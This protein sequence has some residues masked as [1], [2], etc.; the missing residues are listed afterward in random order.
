MA[1]DQLAQ[2]GVGLAEESLK[3]IEE[4]R[5]FGNATLAQ[6]RHNVRSKRREKILVRRRRANGVRATVR[7]PFA[8]ERWKRRAQIRFEK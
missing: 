6:Q 7:L 4:S 5:R 3:C 2:N 1:L 8:A